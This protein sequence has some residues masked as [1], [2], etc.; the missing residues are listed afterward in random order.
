[1]LT[2]ISDAD[3]TEQHPKHLMGQILVSET[4]QLTI[5]LQKHPEHRKKKKRRK[6]FI[7]NFGGEGTRSQHGPLAKA[8]F[9]A[10]SKTNKVGFAQIFSILNCLFSAFF[11]C[12]FVN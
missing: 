11:N 9:K 1:M 2:C 6:C 8:A 12:I 4:Q 10:Q 5:F 3:K 7:L